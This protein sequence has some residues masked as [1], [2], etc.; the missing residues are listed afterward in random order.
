M[1][2]KPLPWKKP[3]MFYTDSQLHEHCRACI[4]DNCSRC[5]ALWHSRTRAFARWCLFY[6]L[7][8]VIGILAGLLMSQ[9]AENQRLAERLDAFSGGHST[10]TE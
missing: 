1:R 10:N 3:P 6:F 5:P 8:A 9:L 4:V 7:C 2:A